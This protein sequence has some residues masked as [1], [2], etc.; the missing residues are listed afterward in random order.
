MRSRVVGAAFVAMVSVAP[1][2]AGGTCDNRA[3]NTPKKLLECVT[4]DGARRHQAA[5]QGIADANGGTRVS[6]TSGYDQS[7]DYVAGLLEEAGY[8]CTTP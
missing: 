3:N 5:L 7:A 1:A 2:G 6:G 4:L 8:A